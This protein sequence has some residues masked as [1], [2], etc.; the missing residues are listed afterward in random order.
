MDKTPGQSIEIHL[1]TLAATEAFAAELAKVLEPGM[2]VYL[3]GVL[4]A[5][6]TTLV[7]S[8]L[9]VRGFSGRVKS[10]TY[11][12]VE[13]YPGVAHFDLYRLTD[14]EEL[15]WLGV[16]DYFAGDTLCFVEWPEKGVGVLPQPDLVCRLEVEGSGRKLTLSAFSQGGLKVLSCPGI[17]ALD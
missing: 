12:L 7:R 6:K 15:E 2:V 8:V 14:P 16:R 9:A 3:E 1:P 4:G 5:G 17:A 10:P 13:V 11:T